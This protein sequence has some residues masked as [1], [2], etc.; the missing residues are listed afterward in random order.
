M[1]VA[2]LSPGYER[3][4]GRLIFEEGL[5]M[6][7]VKRL[8]PGRADHVYVGEKTWFERAAAN[9]Q[10]IFAALE[11]ALA[12]TDGASLF[13]FTMG[14]GATGIEREAYLAGWCVVGRLLAESKSLADLAR[15]PEADMPSLVQEV[16]RKFIAAGKDRP[17]A[18]PE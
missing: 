1:I 8:L 15:I 4:L 7:A 10:P 5:A 12:A 9:R 2:G 3:T 13:K 16:L 17:H 11:P 14:E 18:H 6:H